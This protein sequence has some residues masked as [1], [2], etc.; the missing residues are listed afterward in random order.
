MAC[1]KEKFLEW[2]Q[3]YSPSKFVRS[4]EYQELV[5]SVPE[6]V[7]KGIVHPFLLQVE[8]LGGAP[9]LDDAI[10]VFPV[11]GADE[12]ASGSV[13]EFFEVLQCALGTGEPRLVGALQ[14]LCSF[15]HHDLTET[16]YTTSIARNYGILLEEFCLYEQYMAH[17]FISEN[18]YN[19]PDYDLYDSCYRYL[20]TLVRLIEPARMRDVLKEARQMG[21]G[22]ADYCHAKGIEGV[23]LP[24]VGDGRRAHLYK[25]YAEIMRDLAS[26]IMSG[27]TP[28]LRLDRISQQNSVTYVE[29]LQE[30][31]E[32]ELYQQGGVF[33]GTPLFRA[34]QP[35]LDIASCWLLLSRIGVELYG[36][37]GA[38]GFFTLHSA[39]VKRI[40]KERDTEGVYTL[41][42]QLMDPYQRAKRMSDKP[43]AVMFRALSQIGDIGV[44]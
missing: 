13:G 6:E 4:E 9:E 3:D 10:V 7:L 26:N 5:A 22:V 41:Y 16:G 31:P 39:E 14:G 20:H 33:D 44:Y 8:E 23:P 38:R 28:D 37:A 12:W 15:I 1:E 19:E 42:T 2:V 30:V 34:P 35:N 27:K 25:T 11:M 24:W 43:G 17:P 36:F 32:T 29:S 40:L 21:V 18:D